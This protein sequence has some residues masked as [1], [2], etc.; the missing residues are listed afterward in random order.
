MR[1]AASSDNSYG[2][3]IEERDGPEAAYGIVVDLHAAGEVP[4]VQP[5]R[6]PSRPAA[7]ASVA[8]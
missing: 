6:G 7:V 8:A 2:R 4:A 1:M 3:S 5:Y